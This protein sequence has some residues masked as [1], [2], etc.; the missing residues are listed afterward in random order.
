MGIICLGF[1]Q[2]TAV[3]SVVSISNLFS[4]Q[5]FNHCDNVMCHLGREVG[6]Y[7]LI[8]SR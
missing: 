5:I 7:I 1:I 4:I 6:G 3:T 2:L 8:T